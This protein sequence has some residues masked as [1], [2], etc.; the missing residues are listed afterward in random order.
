MEEFCKGDFIRK[1]SSKVKREFK[2]V[3]KENM[4]AKLKEKA[5]DQG[6]WLGE[7][8]FSVAN[9]IVFENVEGNKKQPEATINTN[10][11]I[12]EKLDSDQTE[13]SNQN[14]PLSDKE[15]SEEIVGLV[16]EETINEIFKEEPKG[17]GQPT[18]EKDQKGKEKGEGACGSEKKSSENDQSRSE[19]EG[20]E[21]ESIGNGSE[22]GEKQ[23]KQKEKQNTKEIEKD[24]N[25][26]EKEKEAEEKE[27]VKKE[28]KEEK[29]DGDKGN[30]DDQKEWNN[31]QESQNETGSE[32]DGNPKEMEREEEKQGEKER[33]LEL[34]EETQE[35]QKT[36]ENEENISEKEENVKSQKEKGNGKSEK[37]T[38]IE[39]REKKENGSQTEKNKR[40]LDLGFLKTIAEKETLSE[41]ETGFL[42]LLSSSLHDLEL[43]PVQNEKLV[44]S[45]VAHLRRV[46]GQERFDQ[47]LSAKEKEIAHFKFKHEQVQKELDKSKEDNAKLQEKSQAEVETQN[48][49]VKR[50][51]DLYREL[52]FGVHK[53]ALE[54]DF[55]PS[56]M[57]KQS[58]KLS[59]LSASHVLSAESFWSHKASSVLQVISQNIRSIRTHLNKKNSVILGQL[60]YVFSFGCSCS[61]AGIREKKL[62]K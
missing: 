31:P 37:E 58:L 54:I 11:S 40:E 12:P 46:K 43:E 30:Q 52:S 20:K 32:R 50:A 44:R 19:M 57:E 45:L 7:A 36:K 9:Q 14:P 38:Q 18:E 55:D 39:E 35:D 5:R 16:L 28:T 51:C 62:R 26:A 13:E 4:L 49:T 53:A 41:E 2:H 17:I 15:K 1:G 27:E 25:E 24:P 42:S 3:L 22:S 61:G 21:H 60:K 23:P 6:R 56:G 33:V 48:K 10:D 8:A 59:D 29:D 34:K 47:M